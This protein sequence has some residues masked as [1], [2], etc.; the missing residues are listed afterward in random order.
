[1]ERTRLPNQLAG[2]GLEDL[3]E[4]LADLAAPVN[5]REVRRQDQSVIGVAGR[6][7]LI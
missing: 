3:P 4:Q 6:D 7:K 1:V 2:P 5:D